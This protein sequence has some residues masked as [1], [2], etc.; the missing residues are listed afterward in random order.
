MKSE[1]TDLFTL[2]TLPL[3]LYLIMY[4][5]SKMKLVR[6]DGHTYKPQSAKQS[7]YQILLLM[8]ELNISKLS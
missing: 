2:Q 8:V 1:L 4:I 7:V 3:N 5:G 6:F